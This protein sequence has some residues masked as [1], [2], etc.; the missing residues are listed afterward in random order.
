MPVLMRRGSKNTKEKII[1]Q[2]KYLKDRET[3]SGEIRFENIWDICPLIKYKN[4]FVLY[5]EATLVSMKI[6]LRSNRAQ[7][8]IKLDHMALLHRLTHYNASEIF[9][10]SL[11][12]IYVV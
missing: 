5:P 11:Y 10:P 9:F 1:K 2:Q 4:N 7:I 6:L 3:W 8:A 12:T